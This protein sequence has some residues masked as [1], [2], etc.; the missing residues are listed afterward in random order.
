MFDNYVKSGDTTC[1]MRLI[2]LVKK[3]ILIPIL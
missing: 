2:S 1:F 3:P